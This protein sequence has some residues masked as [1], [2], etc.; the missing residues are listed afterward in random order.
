MFSFFFFWPGHLALFC[1]AASQPLLV[2]GI[3]PSRVQGLPS[4]ICAR[5]REF[6]SF[7]HTWSTALQLWPCHRIVR[8]VWH[9]VPLVI[10]T[11]LL[12]FILC[13][14]S[15][16]SWVTPGSIPKQTKIQSE[17]QSCDSNISLAQLVPG[18]WTAECWVC[19][20]WPSHG[21]APHPFFMNTRLN[22]SPHHLLDKPHQEIVI[23]ILT[24]LF[25]RRNWF[26][27]VSS[28]K[29][30]TKEVWISFPN[31]WVIV[32]TEPFKALPLLVL[33][34]ATIFP[35][36]LWEEKSIWA[37]VHSYWFIFPFGFLI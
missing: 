26:H 34:G 27:E 11:W 13:V 33:I 21:P 1:K 32:Q 4:V 8:L 31:Y 10:P 9:C 24:W 17:F 36:W 23:N 30:Q 37:N 12:L 2:H 19:C 28:S 3:I 22:A 5:T 35:C 16:M 25:M 7:F 6:P 18:C 20:P 15:P 29:L 14:T